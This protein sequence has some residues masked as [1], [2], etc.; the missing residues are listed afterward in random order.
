MPWSIAGPDDSPLVDKFISSREEYCVSL[1]SRLYKGARELEL[2]RGNSGL[3]L[4]HRRQEKGGIDGSAYFESS[5]FSFSIQPP[6]KE[7][8]PPWLAEHLLPYR[9]RLFS[10][11]GVRKD[12][13]RFMEMFQLRPRHR[14]E[15][16]IMVRDPGNGKPPLDCAGGWKILRG[17]PENQA[18]LLPIQLLYEEEEVL[19]PGRRVNKK[20]IAT[21]LK[22]SLEQQRLLFIEKN[23]IV[24][25]KAQ[26]NARG[27]SVEQIGGVY[28]LAPL[29]N[30]GLATL[31]IERLS[32]EIHADGKSAALFVKKHNSAAIR[33]YEKCGY[34]LGKDFSIAYF[35]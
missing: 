5:G 7:P 24:L 12:C 10:T 1:S 29:R 25:A 15:Y 22:L 2:P 18:I 27:K 33:L 28:T 34:R 9:H 21:Q 6:R 30:R 3:L 31:L 35:E 20:F 23:G 13:D 11:M 19:I 17:R 8:L 14:V 32:T 16:H 26:T 4:L